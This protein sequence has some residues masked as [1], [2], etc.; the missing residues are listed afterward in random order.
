MKQ[1]REYIAIAG[2]YIA[3]WIMWGPEALDYYVPSNLDDFANDVKQSD[4]DGMFRPKNEDREERAR[5]D[6]F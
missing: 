3:F 4:W 6:T 5:F 2:A 1:L